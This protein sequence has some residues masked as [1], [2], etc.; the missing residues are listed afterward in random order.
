MS[1]KRLHDQHKST[2]NLKN[3]RFKRW[4][5]GNTQIANLS[6]RNFDQFRASDNNYNQR[7][8]HA[9]CKRKSYGK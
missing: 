9:I 1:I 7:M 6:I 2:S 8:N 3:N 4:A 5:N